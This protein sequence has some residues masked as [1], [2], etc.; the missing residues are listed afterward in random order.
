MTGGMTPST[1][2]GYGDH[3]GRQGSTT[4]NVH[5]SSTDNVVACM[6]SEF[7]DAVMR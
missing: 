6:E 2:R 1:A 4:I 3:T 5:V 7:S